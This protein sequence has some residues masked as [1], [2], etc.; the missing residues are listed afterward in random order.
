MKDAVRPRPG[1]G[2]L[3]NNS[4]RNSRRSWASSAAGSAVATRGISS[5]SLRQQDPS[6]LL[7]PRPPLIR[8]RVPEPRPD[9]RAGPA[10]PPLALSRR[11]RHRDHRHLMIGAEREPLAD[12]AKDLRDRLQR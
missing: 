1:W 6:W 3:W 4:E 2:F 7:H 10:P 5:R 9:R 11:R 8:D 12:A